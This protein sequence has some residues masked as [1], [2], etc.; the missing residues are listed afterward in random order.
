MWILVMVALL[1]MLA[2]AMSDGTQTGVRNMTEQQ[3]S[4][5]ASEILDYAGTLKRVIR[6]LQINGCEDTEISFAN[7]VMAGYSNPNA[8]NDNSCHVFHPRGGGLRYIAPEETWLDNSFAEAHP[9]NYGTLRFTTSPQIDGVGTNEAELRLS[10]NFLRVD[11]CKALNDKAGIT[12]PSNMPP[13]EENDPA[14]GGLFNGTYGA[15]VANNIGDDG[16]HNL[17]GKTTFCRTGSTSHQFTQVLI[18]R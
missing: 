17:S 12:N 11:L 3:V 14:A 2:Y 6:E 13:V 5:A 18:A 4:M 10:I 1:G 8:P 9:G 7:A 16:G 15:P